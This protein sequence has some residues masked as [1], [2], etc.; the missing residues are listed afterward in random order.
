MLMA[1]SFWETSGGL[2]LATAIG[3]G[4]GALVGGLVGVYG[5]LRATR[6]SIRSAERT[7]QQ[8]LQTQIDLA[9]EA[10]LQERFQDTYVDLLD[11]LTRTEQHVRLV[12]AVF[13]SVDQKPPPVYPDLDAWFH[14]TARVQAYATDAVIEGLAGVQ[15]SMYD[16]D[17]PA[18]ELERAKAEKADS[19]VLRSRRQA[20]NE[21]RDKV[22]AAVAKTR[23]AAVAD[24]RRRQSIRSEFPS[25][26][27]RPGGPV[28]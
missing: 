21:A 8:A 24:L 28:F 12:S 19:S 16:F 4:I 2:A 5:T 11:Y 22:F 10:R 3:A 1:S 13:R 27:F 18:L 9:Q 15:Q 17:I 20:L 6:H 23:S 25:I 7:Q 26:A 14:L